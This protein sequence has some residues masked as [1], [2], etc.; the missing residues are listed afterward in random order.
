MT[1]LAD[2]RPAL[3]SSRAEPP[4]AATDL[5]SLVQWRSAHHD[6]WEARLA[7]RIRLGAV[8]REGASFVASDERGARLGRYPSLPEAEAAVVATSE[9]RLGRVEARHQVIATAVAVTTGA[10]ATAVAVIGTILIIR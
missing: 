3:R 1:A 7:G 2:P 6:S 8:R 4:S 5:A 9:A 10:A